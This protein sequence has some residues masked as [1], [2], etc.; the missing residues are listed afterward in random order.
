MNTPGSAATGA[1]E[2]VDEARLDA[3][4]SQPGLL[5]IDFWQESCP[6]CRALEP[7]VV[8]FAECHSEVTVVRVDIDTDLQVAQRLDVM[9]IP[10]VLVLRDG[11]EV[12]RLDGLI[13]AADLD[14]AIA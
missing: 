7:K 3:L 4:R 12:G 1:I 5:V 11:H 9:T 13:T 14:D 6:P 8:T 10:T 2:T